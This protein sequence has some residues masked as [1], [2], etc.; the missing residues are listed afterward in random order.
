M[1]GGALHPERGLLPPAEAIAVARK[2]VGALLGVTGEPGLVRHRSWPR[3]IPQYNLGYEAF[4]KALE[5]VEMAQPGLLIGGHVRD[6]IALS[7]CLSAGLKLAQ[8]AL[9]RP[10]RA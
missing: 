10:N 3:A 7:A 6:G 8:R 1:L 4:L 5:T 9:E 2:E